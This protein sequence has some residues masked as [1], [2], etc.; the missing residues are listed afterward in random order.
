MPERT[1]H[2]HGTPSWVDV[3]A[4]D[5]PAARAFYEGLFGWEG[6]DQ[7]PQ[8]GG[9]VMWSLG[10]RAVAALSPMSAEMS[11]A[12]VRPAWTTY[13]TVDDADAAAQ[14]AADAGG[15]VVMAPFDVFDAGRMAMLRDPTGGHIAVWQ[16]NTHIGA[17]VVNEPGALCWNELTVR[18]VDAA[19]PFYQRVFG[20]TVTSQDTPQ[21]MPRYW[22]L[23]AGGVPVAGC[24][25]MDDRWPAEVPTHWMPY[26][27]VAD[28]DAA[29]ARVTGLGGTVPVPPTDIPPGRF[30]VCVDPN[31]AA[32]S[33]ITLREGLA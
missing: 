16:P 32:F 30:A 19:L 27:A 26:F 24:I 17:G 9:Y 2:P 7:G 1:S 15:T 5:V 31:G 29:A 10:G 23:A 28:C 14:A 25:E 12:G 20:W 22:E 8:A 21:G 33:V 3:L 13:V 4:P 18:D 6:A 11:E